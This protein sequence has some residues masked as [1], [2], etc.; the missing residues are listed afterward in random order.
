MSDHD[1]AGVQAASKLRSEALLEPLTVRISMAVRL[2]GLGRSK[3]YELIK[4]GEIETIKVGA[5]T[6]VTMSSLR[7]LLGRRLA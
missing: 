5:A 6:L 1:V 4:S 2:T 7:R 3:L